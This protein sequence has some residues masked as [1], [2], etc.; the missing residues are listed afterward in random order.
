MNKVKGKLRTRGTSG[1]LGIQRQFRIM[2]D[3]FDKCISYPEFRKAM[4]DYKM[5]LNDEEMQ[6]LF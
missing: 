5:N 4:N 2:D 3:D 6:A 1:M